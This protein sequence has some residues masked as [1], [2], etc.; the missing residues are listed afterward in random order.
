MATK[1]NIKVKDLKPTKDA[2][3]GAARQTQGSTRNKNLQGGGRDL[4]GGTRMQ[5]GTKNLN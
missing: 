4:D 1:K 5:G 2:K 3:G